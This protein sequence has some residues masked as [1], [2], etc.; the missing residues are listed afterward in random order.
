ME[1]TFKCIFKSI[2]FFFKYSTLKYTSAYSTLPTV[3]WATYCGFGG[4]CADLF[5]IFVRVH[6]GMFL[7]EP[8]GIIKVCLYKLIIVG[9]TSIPSVRSF[10]SDRFLWLRLTNF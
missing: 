5:C 7:L 8:A 10:S 4:I 2:D 3:F 1:L 9:H 6:L